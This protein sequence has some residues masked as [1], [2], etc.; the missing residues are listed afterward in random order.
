MNLRK[1]SGSSDVGNHR[2]REILSRVP[3]EPRVV[4]AIAPSSSALATEIVRQARVARSQTIVELA[5]GTGS[6]DWSPKRPRT[7]RWSSRLKSIPPLHKSSRHAFRACRWSRGV[8]HK[9]LAPAERSPPSV[10]LG[11]VRDACGVAQCAAGV[12]LCVRAI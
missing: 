9:V 4:G 3:D 11:R 10:I 5:G 8:I 6:Q 2:S 1:E 7:R 12:R